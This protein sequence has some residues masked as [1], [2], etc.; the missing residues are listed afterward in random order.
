MDRKQFTIVFHDVDDLEKKTKISRNGKII[1][2]LES[3]HVTIDPMVVHRGKV[4]RYLV[5]MILDFIT[6]GKVQINMYDYIKK[7]IDSLPEDTKE[8]N[9][10]AAL[11]YRFQTDDENTIILLLTK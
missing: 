11:V 3:I 6:E 9:H 8:F 5:G 10:T 1:A 4:H 2:K 7:L